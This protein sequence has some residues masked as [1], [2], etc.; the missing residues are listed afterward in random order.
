MRHSYF[1]QFFSFESRLVRPHDD[2]RVDFKQINL[3]ERHAALYL[4]G[5]HVHVREPAAH[6]GVFF[7]CVFA[8]GFVVF[9][10]LVGACSYRASGGMSW[11][12][13]IHIGSNL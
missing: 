9:I 7:A 10:V 13:F 5:A 1:Y 3:P 6:Y 12:Q 4:A 11:L 2:P 8:L